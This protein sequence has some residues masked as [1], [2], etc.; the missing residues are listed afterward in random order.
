MNTEILPAFSGENELNTESI[1][2]AAVLLRAGEV[3]GIPTE[4]VYG[5][6]A[7]AFDEKAVGKIFQ[8]K[9]RPQDNPLIVHISSFEEIR[10]LVSSVPEAAKK[11]ADAFWS[12]PLTVILPKSDKIPDA[13][14]AGLP[15]V[16][17]RMPS[18]PVAR[19]VIQRAGVPLAAPSANLSGSPSPTNAKY[20]FDDM[21]GRIP[22]ILDGGSSAV[23]VESTVITLCTDIPRVLRPGGVTVEQLRAVLGEVE[24]DDAVLHQLK[25]GEKAAS[26][27]MKY[28]HYAPRADI[29][30]VRGSLEQFRKYVSERESDAFVLCFAGEEAYFKRAVT[31]GAAEDDSTQANRLFDAL[32]ELDEQGAKTVYARCPSLA[33]VGL[34]VY[35]RLIRAAGF[36][37]VELSEDKI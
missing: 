24:V 11:L 36:H 25:A 29:T 35:N 7:N 15:S 2:R 26:P 21:H 23:G 31:Y 33:G 1:D 4:T 20:V 32:R 34:A 10:A 9:G 3:V 13:V 28:K 30:I 14:S 5:L 16:A 19:A 8:A 6:A 37:L 12:G 17:V 18:H 27:G 22:L